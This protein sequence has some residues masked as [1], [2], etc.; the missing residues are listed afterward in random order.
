V[1]CK[2]LRFRQ[3]LHSHCLGFLRRQ[4]GKIAILDAE[5][6]FQYTADCPFGIKTAIKL[7]DTF[8]SSVYASAREFAR[9]NARA[10]VVYALEPIEFVAG[11]GAQ[12][13]VRRIEPSPLFRLQFGEPNDTC[14]DL[15]HILGPLL[16]IGRRMTRPRSVGMR[17]VNG[18]LH[19]CVAE[20]FDTKW[21]VFILL[22]PVRELTAST[23]ILPAQAAHPPSIS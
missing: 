19:D 16:P 18:T 9:T 22:Y 15:D 23:I 11:K 6:P 10:C 12:A 7:A 8:G 1:L 5:A 21:N 3:R 4:L 20:A 14:I 2:L 17:D 13:R